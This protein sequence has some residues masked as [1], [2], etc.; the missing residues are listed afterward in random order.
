VKLSSQQPS[1]RHHA[2]F[3]ALQLP[4]VQGR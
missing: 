3:S 4:V 2:Q 1:I